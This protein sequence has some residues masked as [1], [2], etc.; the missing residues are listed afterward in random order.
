M[1]TG[2]PLC[3]ITI[4]CRTETLQCVKT[5]ST[6]W[7]YVRAAANR[8]GS[9]G[10]RTFCWLMYFSWTEAPS[11]REE[12][13]N[14]FSGSKTLTASQLRTACWRTYPN[15]F[16]LREKTME[17]VYNLQ[18]RADWSSFWAQGSLLSLHQTSSPVGGSVL[19]ANYLQ[20]TLVTAYYLIRNIGAFWISNHTF[21]TFLRYSAQTRER[22]VVSTDE[23]QLSEQRRLLSNNS[24]TVTGW[25]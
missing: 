2:V 3:K 14:G 12:T 20:V 18:S 5:H 19:Y 25:L 1:L 7:E 22:W 6:C 4:T 11:W 15:M 8:P 16:R 9:L 10:K 21:S 23:T 17:P 24:K 13:E